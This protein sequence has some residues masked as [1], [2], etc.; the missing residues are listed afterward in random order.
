MAKALRGN[1]ISL[2]KKMASFAKRYIACR[3]D[4][5]YMDYFPDDIWSSMGKENLLG[6]SLPVEY[7][8]LGGD[9]LSIV[10]AGEALVRQGHNMGIAMSWLTHLAVSRFLIGSYGDNRQKNTYLSRLACGRITVSI[11][12]SEPG[13]GAHPK[14]LETSAYR[15]GE[16]Y[17]LNGEKSYLTNGPI[18][19]L[20][21]VIAS[22]GFEGG[23]KR[24]TAF[25]V[26][27]DTVGLSKTEPMKFDFFKPS[28]HGGIILSNCSVPVTEILGE[29]GFAYEKMVKPFRDLEDALKMGLLVGGMERQ[30]E[31]LFHLMGKQGISLTN[32]LKEDLG[33]MRSIIDTIRIL[34]YEGASMFDSTVK[35]PELPSLLISGRSLSKKFQ[36]NFRLFIKK[37]GIDEDTD[38]HLFTNDLVHGINMGEKI[39]RIKQ[40]KLGE[41][42][43]KGI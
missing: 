17:V 20:F 16:F 1:D 31:I 41:S 3:D 38:M 40:K 37:A 9:Y 14:H 32:E 36:D 18:A 11:A 28:P 43:L 6:L 34:A 7:G 10:V 2:Q 12:V 25:F 27:Q 4:L 19:D 13:R 26:S 24:Y 42:L 8:G 23:R 29:E 5:Y 33:R 15:R 22:T 39:A 35:E 21:I 30:V